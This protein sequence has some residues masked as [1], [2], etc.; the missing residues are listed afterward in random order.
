[1]HVS[2]ERLVT[3]KLCG[4]TQHTDTHIQTLSLSLFLSVPTAS[5]DGSLC[6]C[7]VHCSVVES[8]EEVVGISA[9]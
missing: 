3:W 1:M 2:N 6:T 8:D 4:N 7:L 9:A 5:K